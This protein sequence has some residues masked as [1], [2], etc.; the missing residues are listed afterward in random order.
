MRKAAREG[1]RISMGGK[2]LVCLANVAGVLEFSIL[3]SKC[4]SSIDRFLQ[5]LIT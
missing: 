4:K 5:F 3:S 2:E 1:R